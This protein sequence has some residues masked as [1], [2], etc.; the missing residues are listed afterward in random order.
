[1][2]VKHENGRFFIEKDGKMTAEMSYVPAEGQQIE[3]NHTYVAEE[4]RGQGVGE[5]LI[6]E[7]VSYAREQNKKIIPTCSYAKE[8]LEGESEYKDVLAKQ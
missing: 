3:V 8:K 4:L 1:M 6:N 5:K 2:E 7:A